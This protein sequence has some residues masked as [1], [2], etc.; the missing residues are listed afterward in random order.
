MRNIFNWFWNYFNHNKAGINLRLYK[1]KKK[2]L[3]L[4]SSMSEA[5]HIIPTKLLQ[6]KSYVSYATSKRGHSEKSLI[7]S[8]KYRLMPPRGVEPQWYA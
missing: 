3:S 1:K 5:Q 4:R 8:A 7:V 6:H 2:A